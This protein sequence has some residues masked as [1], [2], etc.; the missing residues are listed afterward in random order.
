[1]YS[2]CSLNPEE[3]DGVVDAAISKA[4]DDYNISVIIR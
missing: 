3:N 2:T 1:M 4:M